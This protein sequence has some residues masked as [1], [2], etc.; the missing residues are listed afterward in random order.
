MRSQGQILEKTMCT[1]QRAQF[2]CNLH[3][4]LPECLS[5]LNLGQDQNWVLSG[6]KLGH[7]VKSQKNHVYSLEGTVFI[8]SSWNYIRMFITGKSSS[9]LK[10]GHIGSKTRSPGKNL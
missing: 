7:Q 9:D 8:Q 2:K 10:L 6:Q 3:K 1:L 5:Q 4:T